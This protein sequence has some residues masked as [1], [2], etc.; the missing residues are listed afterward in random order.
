MQAPRGANAQGSHVFLL[1]GLQVPQFP[2]RCV[3]IVFFALWFW[4]LIVVI[5]DLF[6]CD[7]IS[8]WGEAIWVIALMYMITPKRMAERSF[9][10][11]KQV[12]E[13]LRQVV[14]YSI[15][16]EIREARPT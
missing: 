9:Q 7:H 10:Q 16:D 11:A 1:G 15:A 4:L 6:R 3:V 13:E 5:G 8:G 14:G 2:G 12:R